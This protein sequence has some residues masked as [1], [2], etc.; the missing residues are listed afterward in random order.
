MVCQEMQV[1][2]PFP[3]GDTAAQARR[4]NSCPEDDV[5]ALAS[6]CAE[7]TQRFLLGLPAS[8]QYGLALF[9]RALVLR[10][11]RAWEVVYQ[12]YG[13]VV[14]RWAN[15]LTRDPELAAC[16]IVETF[17]RF[18]LAVDAAKLRQFSD[19]PSLLR[20]LKLC[21]QTAA[22]D[23]GRVLARRSVE[24]SP[25]QAGPTGCGGAS[26]T[27]DVEREALD[28]VAR[29]EFWQVIQRHF[30][31]EADRVLAQLSFV[32]GLPPREICRR[33]P[34]LFP[35]VSDVYKVKRNMLDRLRQ[36]AAMRELAIDCSYRPR[37][38]IPAAALS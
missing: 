24:V 15:R 32:E 3:L 11:E 19:L 4:P 12:C 21:L 1:R 5:A 25:E 23:R 8:G 33:V 22:L 34:T 13:P 26:A 38:L 18:W 35:T 16:L 20:Y 14:R 17:E 31:S 2:R 9:R 28:A 37:I 7:E 10:D 29:R 6:H 30:R 36:S 27:I